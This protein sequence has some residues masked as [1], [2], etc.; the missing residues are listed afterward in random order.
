MIASHG[1]DGRGVRRGVQ[2]TVRRFSGAIAARVIEPPG[3]KVAEHHHDWPVLT[4]YVMGDVVRVQEGAEVRENRPA[5]SLNGAGE[6]H[7]NAVGPAG[8]EQIDVEF[9]PDW[10]RAHTGYSDCPSGKTWIGGKLAAQANVL[11]RYWTKEHSTEAQLA[12]LTARLLRDASGSISVNEPRW[13][14]AVLAELE[15]DDI[16]STSTLA[17]RLGLHPGWLAQSYR[18]AVG[19][20]LCQTITRQRVQRAAMLLRTTDLPGAAIAVDAG[21]CDQS[22][23]I[24]SFKRL[25]GRSP[26]RVRDEGVQLSACANTNP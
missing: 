15:Q 21:F 23:M 17:R 25:L 3:L 7:S 2:Q 24:R 9:D 20:G 4:F 11:R 22:H 26:S 10:L 1:Q 14:S 8:L 5:L 16:P 12:S 19:E 6:A 18:A 13:L